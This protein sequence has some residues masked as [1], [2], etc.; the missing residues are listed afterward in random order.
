MTPFS[1]HHLL[2]FSQSFYQDS[3]QHMTLIDREL[4]KGVVEPAG[5]E[6]VCVI[7]IWLTS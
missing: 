3:L 1:N 7:L 4:M 2:F 5:I 6:R